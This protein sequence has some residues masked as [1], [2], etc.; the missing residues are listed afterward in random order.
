LS[1]FE[2]IA[3]FVFVGR[4]RLSRQTADALLAEARNFNWVSAKAGRYKD[5]KMVD[6]YEIKELRDVLVARETF[7]REVEQTLK[8]PQVL[9]EIN[10]LF[11]LRL[12]SY[13]G[14]VA[15]R[16]HVGC[17]IK[18]HCDTDFL[19]T[20]RVVTAIYYLNEEYEGGEI[21]FP[22]FGPEVRTSTGDLLLFLSE[23]SHGVKPILNGERYSVIWFAEAPNLFRL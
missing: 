6:V 1:G 8:L 2:Q 19:N 12:R 23:Y 20:R 17:H 4:R 18:A 7:S 5:D 9:D 14:Y 3:P 21:F 15:S 16:Y 10:R 11:G 22:Q 13:S